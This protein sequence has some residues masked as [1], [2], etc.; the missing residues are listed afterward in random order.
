MCRG[1]YIIRQASNLMENTMC[2][3]E[4]GFDQASPTPEQWEVIRERALNRA[5]DERTRALRAFYARG[6]GAL[7]TVV[8]RGRE[9]AGAFVS[10]AVLQAGKWRNNYAAWIARRKA[11]RELGGL[12]DRSLKDMGLHRSEIESV[13]YGRDSA[14]VS[15]GAMAAVLLHKPYSRRSNTMSPDQKRLVNQTAAAHDTHA[16]AA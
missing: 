6:L 2:T 10:R 8:T 1:A 14:R 5:R 13:I 16:A 11:V 3:C 9:I 4:P 15:E 7:T 12:D